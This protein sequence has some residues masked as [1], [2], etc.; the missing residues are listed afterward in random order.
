MTR[1]AS[2]MRPTRS[3]LLAAALGSL[4]LAGGSAVAQRAYPNAASPRATG[5][6]L[7]MDPAWSS[8]FNPLEEES[9]SDLRDDPL[10][11]PLGLA[12]DSDEAARMAAALERRGAEIRRMANANSALLPGPARDPLDFGGDFGPG[13]S[14]YAG[15]G[16]PVTGS[17]SSYSYSSETDANGCTRSTSATQTWPGAPQVAS[18]ATG[19]CTGAPR[20]RAA[21]PEDED[22]DLDLDEEEVEEPEGRN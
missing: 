12:D 9:L 18:S 3:F 16:G 4:A 21:E 7:P 15:V 22:L 20:A 19:N 8:S 17:T 2:T 13:L 5:T 1:K 11:D 6:P 10:F 14:G